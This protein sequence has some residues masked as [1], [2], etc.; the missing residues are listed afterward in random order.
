ML[1]SGQKPLP[2]LKTQMETPVGRNQTGGAEPPT[3]LNASFFCLQSMHSQ[4]AHT[5][6]VFATAAKYRNSQ[7]HAE[8]A[9]FCISICVL[10]SILSKMAGE[11]FSWPYYQNLS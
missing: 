4:P 6:V 3:G 7:C 10:T 11:Q 9:W 1:F 2:T 5:S 8:G